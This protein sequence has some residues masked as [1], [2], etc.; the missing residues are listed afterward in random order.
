MTTP[1][2]AARRITLFVEQYGVGA[3]SMG[4]GLLRDGNTLAHAY[5]AAEARIRELERISPKEQQMSDIVE[6]KK[7]INC[8]V[9][10]IEDASV[11]VDVKR[12]MQGL[13]DEVERRR[14]GRA[15][16]VE[17][18]RQAAETAARKW[19]HAANDVVAAIAALK[20]GAA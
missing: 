18:C 9:F 6:A 17:E 12:I 2:E 1:E 11:L 16:V 10:A 14:A 19:P 20:G 4:N 7:A 8:L 13:V 15:A 3:A 5:L